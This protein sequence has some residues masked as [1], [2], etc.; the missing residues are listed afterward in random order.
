M[1]YCDYRY[2]LDM[3]VDLQKQGKAEI[4]CAHRKLAPSYEAVYIFLECCLAA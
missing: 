3:D 2:E 4:G 1:S